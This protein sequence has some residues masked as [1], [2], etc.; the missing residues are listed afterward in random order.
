MVT[1]VVMVMVII[2]SELNGNINVKNILT[3][4]NWEIHNNYDT[5]L[6]FQELTSKNINGCG[7]YIMVHGGSPG[8]ECGHTWVS[9]H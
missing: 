2:I 9:K 6:S 8:H 4:K 1:V 3:V 7:K 5:H